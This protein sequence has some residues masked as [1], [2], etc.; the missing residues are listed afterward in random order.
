MERSINL[1]TFPPPPQAQTAWDPRGAFQSAT[2]QPSAAYRTPPALPHSPCHY[3]TSRSPPGPL[4]VFTP[5]RCSQ[6][7]E[8]LLCR[9][10]MVT[11]G[12]SAVYG[13]AGWSPGTPHCLLHMDLSGFRKLGSSA[14]TLLFHLDADLERALLLTFS[15]LAFRCHCLPS[16]RA[17]WNSNPGGRLAIGRLDFTI[18]M[19]N[20]QG[21]LFFKGLATSMS[22]SFKRNPISW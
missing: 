6:S 11:T 15:S 3:P 5:H 12:Y 14:N 9:E 8:S 7:P 4:S 2:D 20:L 16:T 13:L 22:D 1:A 21:L 18:R 10:V 17:K 19:E